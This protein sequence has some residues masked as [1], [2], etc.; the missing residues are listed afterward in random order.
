MR[1]L[2]LPAL[3]TLI[4]LLSASLFVDLVRDDG[5]HVVIISIDGFPAERLWDERVE[6]PTLRALARSGAW[7]KAMRPSMPSITWPNHTTLVTGVHPEKHGVLTNGRFVR[8]GTGK[9]IRRESEVEAMYPTLYDAAHAAGLRTAAVNWPVTRGA[10][11]LD[12]NFP[13][14]PGGVRYTTPKLR[15][16]LAEQGLFADVDAFLQ[17]SIPERDEVWTSAAAHLIRTRK[18]DLLLV[19]LLSVDAASHEHGP[20]SEPA[21]SALEQVDA[22]V[23]RIVRAIEEAGLRKRTTVFV[24]SDHGF[25]EVT[26]TIRP[27]VLL[28]E[29]GLLDADD[30]GHVAAARV[31]VAANGGSAMVFMNDAAD[32]ARARRRLAKAEGIDR[33]LEPSE[34][35]AYGLPLPSANEGIGGLVLIA[36]E[37][38]VFDDAAAGEYIVQAEN[39][40]GT[41]GYLSD[42]GAMQAL[43][44]AAG[45]GIRTG[46]R[47]DAVDNRSV[48]PTAARM[49][50]IHLETAEGA[51]LHDILK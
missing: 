11:T 37:G 47:L 16:E 28:R 44:I 35:A 15:E 27:N 50:G 45:S 3:V 32:L 17:L 14:T 10:A 9:V 31:Q 40:K 36:D 6:L 24:V 25:A 8:S 42:A 21:L 30:D 41:H 19:H 26:R 7:A 22:A 20:L 43:F 5:R 33:I 48:A 13:D 34:F 12:D 23:G 38:V 51:V 2:V 49:L 4:L 46:R 18:P 1:N 39:P 29:A